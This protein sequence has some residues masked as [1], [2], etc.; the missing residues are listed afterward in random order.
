MFR[1]DG[2]TWDQVPA[3]VN[4]PVEGL[5]SLVAQLRD[6]AKALEGTMD[7]KERAAMDKELSE[8]KAR[9]QLSD[10]KTAALE[11]IVSASMDARVQSAVCCA[12]GRPAAL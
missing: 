2:S 3:M 1:L 12:T 4:S 7:A 9:Q 11:A 5:V 10:L 8:L 6:T